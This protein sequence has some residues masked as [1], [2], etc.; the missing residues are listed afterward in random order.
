LKAEEY[1]REA[2]KRGKLHHSIILE[3]GN[4]EAVELFARYVIC[5]GECKKASWLNEVL[6]IKPEG[7]SIGISQ[8]RELI[9]RISLKPFAAPWRL[10]VI[11]EAESLTLE[12]AN[13]L[14]KTLE[15]PPQS[16]YFLL[17]TSSPSSLPLTVLSRCLLLSWAG[18]EGKKKREVPRPEAIKTREDLR[19]FLQDMFFLL[20]DWMA[21]KE[22]QQTL[23]FS[24]AQLK[25]VRFSPQD[26]NRFLS[27]FD[28]INSIWDR[29]NLSIV[30]AYLKKIL[31]EMGIG[32]L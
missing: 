20:R 21:W 5:Q 4:Q 8:I 26:L 14:L 27:A 32:Q 15:E 10:V 22:G 19:V 7:K 13:A 25:Q 12:A 24:E 2:S 17:L 30:R 29:A 9:D 16:T 18:E 3:G 31:Q 6:R 1:L 23:Y 11:E 28:R